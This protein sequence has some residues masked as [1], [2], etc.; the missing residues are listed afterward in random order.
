MIELF[1]IGSR[2]EWR[3]K[4]IATIEAAVFAESILREYTNQILTSLGISKNKVDSIRH[5]LSF[6][7]MLNAVLRLSLSPAECRKIGKNIDVVDRLRKIRND[8]VHGIINEE[9]INEEEVRNGIEAT[10]KIV[11]LIKTKLKKINP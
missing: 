10:L 8:L 1:R 5:D 2:L 4:K 11:D 3:R 7:I 9:D 6:N